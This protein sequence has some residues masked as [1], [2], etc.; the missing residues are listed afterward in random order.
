MSRIFLDRTPYTRPSFFNE[1]RF[2]LRR[3]VSAITN[4]SAQTRRAL[5][6]VIDEFYQTLRYVHFEFTIYTDEYY[7]TRRKV[8]LFFTSLSYQTRRVLSLWVLPTRLYGTFRREIDT[9]IGRFQRK[10]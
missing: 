2:Q 5:S 10:Q 4:L 1:L 3:A 6:G 8:I 9:L 7:Q